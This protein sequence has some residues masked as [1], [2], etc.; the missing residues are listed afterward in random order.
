MNERDINKGFRRLAAAVV[1][2][3][4]YDVQR[5]RQKGIIDKNNGVVDQFKTYKE[6]RG[7]TAGQ[8][9]LNYYSHKRQ[10]EE[11]IKFFTDGGADEWIAAGG[12]TVDND[13]MYDKLGIKKK[14]D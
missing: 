2:Q 12:L 11:L 1:R 4:V 14:D 9:V 3:G 13:A 7:R 10:V 8:R 6:A 5:L